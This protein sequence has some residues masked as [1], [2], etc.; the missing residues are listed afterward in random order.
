MC[1]C[2]ISW[3]RTPHVVAKVAASMPHE[4]PSAL[5]V[6]VACRMH[7]V[8]RLY[9]MTCWYQRTSYVPM[10]GIYIACTLQC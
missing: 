9:R 8:L 3:Q 4:N 5:G 7:A 1:V 6:W 10:H 2:R